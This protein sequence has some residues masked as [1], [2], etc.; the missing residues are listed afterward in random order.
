MKTTAIA[1][2]LV[3]LVA[4][5]SEPG[6]QKSLEACRQQI[7]ALDQRMVQIMQERA[8]VVEEVGV[9]KRRANLP[10][11]D[12]GREERVIQKAKEL[13]KEGPLPS[14]IVGRIYQKLVEEMR[15]WEANLEPA[16]TDSRLTGQTPRER[17]R[18]A[19]AGGVSKTF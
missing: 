17:W 16:K 4:L 15:N 14:E 7:D 1:L 2:P 5:R 11:M 9:I 10:I 6:T 13:A 18:T 8:R 12:A 19:C 3:S